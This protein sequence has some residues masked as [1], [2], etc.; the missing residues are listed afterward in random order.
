MSAPKL[1]P[2]QE[3]VVEG[4]LSGDHLKVIAFAGAGKTFTLH[5]VAKALKERN[6]NLR[7][8][9]LTFSRSLKDEAKVKFD[10]LADVYTNHGLARKYTQDVLRDRSEPV[11]TL[12][13]AKGNLALHIP[14]TEALQDFGYGEGEA[15]IPVIE[16]VNNFLYSKDPVITKVHIPLLI[17]L[18]A[19]DFGARYPQLVGLLTQ[20]AQEAW[21][22]LRNPQY[23]CPITHDVYLKEFQLRRPKL[24]YDVILFD[25]AQDA[26]PAMLDMLLSQE[27][28]RILVGDP[29]QQ[30]YAWRGAV[31]AMAQVPGKEV[32]LP[33][34]FRF[35]EGIAALASDLLKKFKG[36]NRSIKG[37][38]N[39]ATD[40]SKAILT[41]TNAGALQ[42]VL[43]LKERGVRVALVRSDLGEYREAILAA[44]RLYQ[45]EKPHHP[46]FSLFRSWNA[47]V[48]L[49]HRFPSVAAQYRPYLRLVERYGRKLPN[50]V[51]TLDELVPED[52]AEVAVSTAHR[53]K[54]KQWTE[55][56]LGVDFEN[57]VLARENAGQGCIYVFE[58]EV[59]LAYVAMTRA[60]THLNQGPFAERVKQQEYYA[61]AV[62][63]GTQ[64]RCPEVKTPGIF[65]TGAKHKSLLGKILEFLWG[66]S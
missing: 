44:Y 30:I 50:I 8:L 6:P 23:G 33:Q 12:L 64:R 21:E 5:Q 39:P 59:N 13:L 31:N 11:P 60:Q 62:L 35:N 53:S 29:H 34:S 47:L 9:Y 45:G 28:Q 2:E 43:R 25:E 16:T 24:P 51:K 66:S 26:N 17:Q 48:D 7:I 61:E 19:E 32:I 54:G 41:R 20:L 36:E 63:K 46:E 3:A 65:P 22:V 38:P 14:K 56:T 4:A 40:G 27:A 37:I 1:T 57:V 18:Q 10:G 52:K 15:V 42:E 49:V 58:D 55:V